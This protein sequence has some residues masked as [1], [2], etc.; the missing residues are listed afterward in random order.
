LA[1]IM[2]IIAA[3]ILGF[4]NHH[5]GHAYRALRHTIAQAS[6]TPGETFIH[7]DGLTFFAERSAV[8]PGVAKTRASPSICGCC[9]RGER[10]YDRRRGGGS[11]AAA[12]P[13][14]DSPTDAPV[15][16]K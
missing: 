14:A 7:A 5:A 9:S 1:A 8:G 15:M 16:L 13:V 10:D 6:L 12:L 11:T 4:I 2:T 3:L